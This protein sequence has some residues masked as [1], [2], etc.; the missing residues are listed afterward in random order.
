[1]F[2]IGAGGAAS[3]KRDRKRQT[4]SQGSFIFGNLATCSGISKCSATTR[5]DKK[6]GTDLTDVTLFYY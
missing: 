6:E 3:L 2:S 1:M 5:V 4:R